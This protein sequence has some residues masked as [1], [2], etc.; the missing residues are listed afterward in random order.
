MKNNWWKDAVVY[1]IYPRSFQDSNG[2]GI[3]DLNGITM[4]L[5][6][7]RDLGADVIWLCPVY[8]SPGADNGYDISDYRAIDPKFGTM[9]DFDRLLREAHKRG[10]RII[11]DMVLNHT[12]DEHPWFTEAR[13]SLDNPYRNYYIWS[14]E[15]PNNWCSWF[16]GSAWEYDGAVD[17]HYL[18]IFAKKQPDLNWSDPG[19]RSEIFSML[20]WWLDKG[21]DGFRLDVISLISKPETIPHTDSTDLSP[22]CI[23]GPHVHEYLREM[24]DQVLSHYDI[25][26]VGE[27][28]GVTADEAK[29][30]AGFERGELNM[31]FQFE[32]TSLTDG[33]YGKWTDVRTS[34]PALKKVFARWQEELRG[35]AW[36]CLFWGNHDQ[37]RA[38]SKF[39]CDLPEY[40]DLSAKML[41]LC[42]YLMQGTPYIYQGDELGMTNAGFFDI[43]RYR[44]I[45]SINFYNDFVGTGTLTKRT[46][47]NYMACVSRD[48]A[49]TPMQWSGELYGGFST[50]EPWICMG[51]NW[52]AVNAQREEND[53]N[54]VLSFYRQVLKYRKGNLLI[55][56]GEFELLLPEDEKLFAYKRTLGRQKLF[57]LCNFSPD[58]YSLMELGMG[59]SGK[60]VLSSY[61]AVSVPEKLRPFEGIAV[62]CERKHKL[63]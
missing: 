24:N 55:R 19:L 53:P 1:Q 38:V 10:I 36:N 17:S 50:E 18:H 54:S 12:S 28:P 20:R 43:E 44:D 57:V 62:L 45:E 3:G 23:N 31:V 52:R 48:N 32:H 56:D 11:M 33:Q 21:V 26:T 2:D 37:P 5:D 6:Y 41:C 46:A 51:Q 14:D 4:R 30:Y 7:I 60:I 8:A 16:G 29:K 9:E 34:L 25:M 27:C 39:G 58:T 49:R 13:S 47:L 59:D 15:K 42:L 35:E 61:G 63:D 22:W 40:R